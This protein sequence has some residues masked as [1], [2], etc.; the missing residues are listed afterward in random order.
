MYTK[1]LSWWVSLKKW[2]T[3]LYLV[4]FAFVFIAVGVLLLLLPVLKDTVWQT[5]GGASLATGLSILVA[6]ITARQSSFEQYRKE[7]NLQCKTDVYGPLH[8][9]LKV[10]RET[11]E[12]ARA[13][14]TP[15]PRWIE[16]SGVERPS[17]LR[18]A[19]TAFLPAFSYWPI[20]KT[21]YRIDNFSPDAQ[22]LLNE[23]QDMAVA[24]GNAVEDARKA[25]HSMLRPHIA[26]S[27]TKEE[28][29]PKYQAWLSK[30][31]SNAA[32]YNRWFSFIYDQRTFVAPTIPLGEGLSYIW[33]VKIGWLLA[34]K[35]VQAALEIYNGDA[36]NWDA[37]Q[38]SSLSWF[39][40]IFE[41]AA[42]ELKNDQ[43]YQK[44]QNVQQ[45]LFTKLLEAEK[46]LYQALLYIRDH[47]EGGP[48]LV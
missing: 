46:L 45:E 47:Y 40:D 14:I 21:N 26:D 13:G 6:A 48:P 20:F 33:S 28:Q 4:A 25:V 36:L 1:K 34:D 19:P 22:K 32:E 37:S 17:S 42:S 44:A 9:E 7:A 35:P 16:I 43:T 38:H 15:Y 29:S 31:T 23:V 11:F 41:A 12:K 30:R 27:I 3:G 5:I 8:A 10:L 2:F 18:Y 39:Q 24:Y